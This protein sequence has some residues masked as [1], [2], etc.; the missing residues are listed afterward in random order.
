[1]VVQTIQHQHL[2]RKGFFEGDAGP[3]RADLPAGYSVLNDWYQDELTDVSEARQAARREQFKKDLETL[4]SYDRGKQSPGQLLST[5][6]LAWFLDNL[7]SGQ[8]FAWHDYPV[9]QLSGVQSNLPSFMDSAHTVKTD[10]DAAAYISRLSKFGTKFDQVLESLY[11]REEKNIIPPRFVIDRVVKEMNEFVSED[12]EENI[13]W[14]SFRDKLAEAEQVSN[15]PALLAKAKAEI[16]KTVFPA[17]HKL[18]DYF[19]ELRSQSSTD[20]GVWRLPRGDEYYAWC[21]RN[22][23]TTSMTPEQVHQLGLSEVDR[24]LAETRTVLESIKR[25][26]TLTVAEHFRELGEDP[27]HQFDNTDEGRTQCIAEY[28]RL[29]DE[30]GNLA[31][32]LFQSQP[33]SQLTVRRIPEFKEATASLALLRAS[34]N[35]WF[36]RGRILRPTNQHGGYA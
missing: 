17:Y 36:A 31:D 26:D 22:H 15:K 5:D 3:T 18:I 21:L 30:L 20:D 29:L 16:T 6:I 4:R 11:V 10:S 7:V 27:Q 1:M 33:K 32:V 28:N 14:F 9:N 19:E 8:E 2:L 23:T 25:S 24:I 12:V 34:R 13:L 35:G